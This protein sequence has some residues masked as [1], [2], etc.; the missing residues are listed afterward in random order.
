MTISLTL[1]LVELSD[2]LDFIAINAQKLRYIPQN[3]PSI[4]RIRPILLIYAETSLIISP[5]K[6]NDTISI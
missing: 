4:G 5:N 6:K 3:E 1:L 2:E